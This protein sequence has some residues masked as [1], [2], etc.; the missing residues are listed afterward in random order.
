[1]S[2]SRT[3]PLA[4]RVWRSS[5]LLAAA[6][7]IVSSSSTALLPATKLVTDGDTWKYFKGTEQP[8]VDWF[9]TDF[10]DS[11]WLEG[12]TPMGYSTDL[13][14]RTV[15]NDM[16][17]AAGY[18]T[19]YFRK[20]FTLPDLGDFKWIRIRARYDDGMI[21]YLNGEELAR[22][23]MPAGDVDKDTPG[24]DH[25]TSPSYEDM[26]LS[27]EAAPT[28]L[29]AGE[30]VIAVEVH[31]S[32][33]DS[34]DFSFTLEVETATTL[35]PFDLTCELLTNGRIRLRWKRTDATLPA[36]VTYEELTLFRNSVM[37]AGPTSTAATTFTD[38]T[39]LPGL[40]TYQ[41][42]ATSCGEECSGAEAPSCAVNTGGAAIFRR[43]DRDD[44]G[45]VGIGDAVTLL[46]GL[47]RGGG[48]PACPDAA[49]FDD[50][51][52]VNIGD[53]VFILSALFRGG[54]QIPPPGSITCGEDPTEDDLGDCTYASD[55]L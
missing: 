25:E 4:R 46:D 53:A 34:S 5:F 45:I 23:S 27:C 1:M 37:L 42:F 6:L 19:V 47:F 7:C 17:G 2:P 38:A 14:Y 32:G 9:A 12:Q 51:G 15:F 40:N 21:V 39:P 31:N 18:L 52:A 10:D 22:R 13:P 41:L 30:N 44:N 35:C 11:A 28:S 50:N 24:L 8:P 33:P 54:E 49:D 3:L 16:M 26:I 55:C 48:D 36:A 29:R 43:G 20:T